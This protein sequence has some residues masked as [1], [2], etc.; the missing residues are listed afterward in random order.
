MRS[1]HVSGYF[2]DNWKVTQDLTLN[3]GLRYD[4]LPPLLDKNGVNALF[5]FPNHAI[6]R[7]ASIADLIRQGAT[8]QAIVNMHLGIGVKF[9]TTKE[10]GMPD[11]LVNVRQR[12]FSPRLGFAYRRGVGNRSLVVRGGYGAYRFPLGARL[13]N[14][15]RSNPP[16]Q[17]TVS[18]NINS[19]AQSPD[20]L[21][22]WGLRSVPTII[23]GTSSAL[24]AIDPNAA[25]AIGRGIGVDV[26]AP[27]LATPVAHE[28]NL[29][30]ETEIMSNTLLRVGYVGTAARNLDQGIQM[31]GQ[32]SNYVHYATTGTPLPTGAYSKVALRN[33]DQTT[34]GAINV[35]STT[36]YSN[37]NGLQ[38]EVQRR[39]SQGLGFQWFYVMSNALWVGSGG[40]TLSGSSSV[41][42]PVT[43]MPGAVPSDFDALNRFLN[44][45]R[46]TEVPKHR[47]NWNV[48]YDLPFGHGKAILH[49][50]GLLNRIV[51]GWQLAAS[52][53]M[54]SRYW[55]LPTGNWGSLDEVQIYGLKHPIEDCRSGTCFQGY[56]DHTGYIPANQ[57]NTRNAAGQCIG[58][59]GVPADYRP[60]HQPIWPTPANPN[61]SD[62]NY[63]LYGTNIVFVPM[64]SGAQQRIGYDTGLHPWR[65]QYMPGPWR[66]TVDSSLFKTI[67]LND[68]LKV[69]LNM[70]FFNVFNAP[71]IPMPE[72]GSGLLSLRNSNV[73]GRE[74]QWTLRLNW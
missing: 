19:A 26:F 70:D 43:F 10:A 32:P 30:L 20:G 59:C 24:N 8:T 49:S 38:V 18:Y 22:N 31:N 52:C 68:R 44:Y 50:R 9:A 16:L 2:Q 34:Y 45:Q 13:F 65:N 33:Y 72:A 61:P 27:N 73:A 29:T 3:L 15:Q 63:A 17:G 41:P 53:S 36:G 66:W 12:N 23:T 6:V 60:S 74:L 55:A 62:P 56:L 57:I 69:R 14:A 71:G 37:Y 40:G 42:D 54:N 58:V 1:S 5:D 28:W 7:T 11:S 47:V 39:F 21:A 64:K 51:G 48:L 46:D 67:P 4:F 35:Y 25:N